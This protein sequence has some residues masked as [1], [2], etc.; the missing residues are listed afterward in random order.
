MMRSDV[1]RKRLFQVPLTERLPPA[2]Y[3]PDS[4]RRVYAVLADGARRALVAGY[5]VCVDGVFARPEERA[6]IETVAKSA[7]APFTGIWLDAPLAIR[8]ARVSAR[9]NDASDA[10]SAVAR[11]QESFDVGPLSW[12]RVDASGSVDQT[13]EKARQV[14]LPPSALARWVEP[15]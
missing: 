5:S 13:L 4:S 3:T 1:V 10:N 15:S 14:G 7:G 2:T 9:M 8:E 6:M 11:V 12:R